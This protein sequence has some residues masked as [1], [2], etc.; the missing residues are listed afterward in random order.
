[1]A[2]ILEAVGDYLQAEGYG[3]QGTDI[4]LAVMPETPDACVAVYENAGNRPE[5]TMGSAPWAVDRPLIQV[6]CRG[7]R[8]DYP[9]TR[10]TAEAIRA[11]LGSVMNTTLSSVPILRIE[12]QGS[13]VPMGEDE[14]QRPMVSVNFE[15]M[16]RYE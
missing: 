16:V 13:V 2:T 4:F 8:S 10:N 7:A 9:T 5:F 6:I 1:M 3:T 11:L 15:C 14:N 12:P